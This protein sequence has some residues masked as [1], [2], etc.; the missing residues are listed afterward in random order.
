MDKAAFKSAMEA[1]KK[2]LAEAS[3]SENV[4]EEMEAA[5]DALLQELDVAKNK[6][7]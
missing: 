3:K 6:K 5:V 1:F 4:K 7:D 2:R